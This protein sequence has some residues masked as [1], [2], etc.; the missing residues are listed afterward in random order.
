MPCEVGSEARKEYLGCQI[1]KING[2]KKC[3]SHPCRKESIC[4]YLSYL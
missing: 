2:K 4:L 3:R 1:R